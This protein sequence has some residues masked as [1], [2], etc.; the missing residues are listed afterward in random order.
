MLIAWEANDPALRAEHFLIVASYNLQHPA[1][2]TDAALANLRAGL[3]E[4]LDNGVAVVELRRR[5]SWQFAG[6]TR[7][8]KPASERRPVLRRWSTT[9]ADV[10]LADRP[11]GAAERVWAWAAAI[12]REMGRPADPSVVSP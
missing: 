10:Y 4:R 6:K 2:L 1:H 8:L 11:A 12:R 7:V 3:I 5:A 9:I